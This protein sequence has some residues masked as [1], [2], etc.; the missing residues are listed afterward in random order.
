MSEWMNDFTMYLTTQVHH[1]QTPSPVIYNSH[2]KRLQRGYLYSREPYA[3]DPGKSERLENFSRFNYWNFLQMPKATIFCGAQWC[4][5][6]AKTWKTK[7][8]PEGKKQ[9]WPM[10]Y[11]IDGTHKNGMKSMGPKNCSGRVDSRSFLG[12]LSQVQKS[13]FMGLWIMRFI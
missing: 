9:R 3:S 5:F 2:S 7:L 6:R 12:N 13:V 4:N 8:K 11:K 10:R 1:Q